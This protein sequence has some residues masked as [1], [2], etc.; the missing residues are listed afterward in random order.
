MLQI[1]ITEIGTGEARSIQ[2]AID[3]VGVAK[4]RIRQIRIAMCP[5]TPVGIVHVNTTKVFAAQ[6]FAG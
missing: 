3:K 4:V 5:K 2:H 6:I 1:G